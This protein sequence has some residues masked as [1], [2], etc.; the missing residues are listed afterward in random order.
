MPPRSEDLHR[1]ESNRLVCRWCHMSIE[2]IQEELRAT[3]G[4][5]CRSR[6]SV[7]ELEDH[8]ELAEK[9]LQLAQDALVKTGYYRAGEVGDD[10]AARIT[11]LWA[12]VRRGRV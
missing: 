1:W 11:E 2:Q 8:L 5:Q 4:I 3:G 9:R 7:G 6:P 12:A 10:I